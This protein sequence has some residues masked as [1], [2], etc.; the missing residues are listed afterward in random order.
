MLAG[1]VLRFS[2]VCLRARRTTA[3]VR[4]SADEEGCGIL[5]A[6]VNELADTSSTQSRRVSR[7]GPNLVSVVL[8]FRNEAETIPTMIGRLESMFASARVAYK[9][10]YVNDASTDESLPILLRE[11]ERNPRVKILNL[12]RRFGVAGGVIAGMSAARGDVIVYMDADLQDPPE[13][14]PTLLARWRE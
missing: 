5:P 14:I 12:S 10:I 1:S 3:R 8:S 4:P 13:L 11:H 7:Q 9:L 2:R 6:I